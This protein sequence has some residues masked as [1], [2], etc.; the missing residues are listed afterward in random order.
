MYTGDP[1]VE[2]LRFGERPDHDRFEPG[3]MSPTVPAAHKDL[4]RFTVDFR[5]SKQYMFKTLSREMNVYVSH[6][7]T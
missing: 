3:V 4:H 1:N 6:M 7:L 5:V 2:H